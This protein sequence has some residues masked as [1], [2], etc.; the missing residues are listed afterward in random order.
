MLRSIGIAIAIFCSLFL[1]GIVNSHAAEITS[2][3]VENGASGC[4]A[5]LTTDEDIWVINWYAKQTYPKS[6]ADDDYECVHV[7]G[8]PP[9]TTSVYVN[10][11]YLEGHIK[12]AEYDIKAEAVFS[13]SR[14]TAVTAVD[15]YGSIYDNEIKETG[16]YG[17]S[18]L[19]AHYFDGSAII[20]EGG[21]SA[22]NGTNN[23]A[24]ITGRFR[25]TALNKQL[26]ELEEVLPTK[27]LK[28]SEFVHY[29]T[30]DWGPTRF[31]FPTTLEQGDEWNC[32]AYLRLQVYARGKK[33]EWWV[34]EQNTFDHRDHR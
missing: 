4:Y 16:V 24:T 26:D 7:S 1:F 20:M 18:Y 12:I 19:L 23:K 9:D 2:L 6:E 11:G 17:R 25:H 5:S 29:T 3:S 8:H 14:D 28:N 27:I 15:V 34:N 32:D 30:S 13:V 10:I 31:H 22:Y 33:D 21:A